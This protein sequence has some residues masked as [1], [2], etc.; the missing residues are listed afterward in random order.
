MY[1][2]PNKTGTDHMQFKTKTVALKTASVS[3]FDKE[4]VSLGVALYSQS[5][6]Y[7]NNISR[8]LHTK[9][10]GCAVFFAISSAQDVESYYLISLSGAFFI[11]SNKVTETENWQS[12][13]RILWKRPL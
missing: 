8:M 13:T 3:H 1:T 4:K 11:E 10:C 9:V 12:Q 6:T 7:L 2:S 5:F